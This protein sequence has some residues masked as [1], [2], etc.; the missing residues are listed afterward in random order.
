MKTADTDMAGAGTRLS[1]PQISLMA[2]R[3]G[4]QAGVTSLRTCERAV[5]RMALMWSVTAAS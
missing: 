4:V 5:L 2:A 3:N 1:Q